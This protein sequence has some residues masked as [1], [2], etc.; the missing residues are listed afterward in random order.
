MLIIDYRLS[1]S[2]VHFL[3]LQDIRE[4]SMPTSSKLIES[5]DNHFFAI[6]LRHFRAAKCFVQLVKHH[7]LEP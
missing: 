4:F 3:L 6:V 7:L 5:S 1:I 2:L